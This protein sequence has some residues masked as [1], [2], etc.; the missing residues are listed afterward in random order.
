ML[1]RKVNVCPQSGGVKHAVQS[2]RPPLQDFTLED[3]HGSGWGLVAPAVFNI[4]GGN[5]A[6]GAVG[7]TPSRSRQPF[8]DERAGRRRFILRKSPFAQSFVG[9][10]R[11]CIVARL[12]LPQRCTYQRRDGT[13]SPS[14][15][16]P[17]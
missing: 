15:R 12:L 4:V 2:L 11:P 9:C 7:S 5:P 3:T 1:T 14:G 8:F 6:V 17:P 13:R 16:I 10:L